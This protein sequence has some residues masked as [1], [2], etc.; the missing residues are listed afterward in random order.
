MTSNVTFSRKLIQFLFNLS[1]IL[2]VLCIVGV[3]AEECTIGVVVGSSTKDGRPILW[4]NRD[5]SFRDNEINFFIGPDY[6]FIGVI[7]ADDT[8]QI[9]AGINTAG[10]AII[11]SESLDLEGDSVD[12]EGFFM[13]KA[14]GICGS[15]ADF[16]QLLQHTN[17]SGRGTKSN[18][19]VIDALGGG[20]IYE[21]G[22]HTYVKFDASDQTTTHDGFIVRANFAM[23]GQGK[24]YSHWRYHCA[25]ELLGQSAPSTGID[26]K[27]ILQSVARDL[28]TDDLDPYPLPFKGTYENG[29]AG[30]INTNNCINRY[31]TACCVVFH[32]VK[33]SE[34]PKFATMWCILGEP[35]CG[36]AVPLWACAGQ[37]PPE[38]NGNKQSAINL[39]IQRFEKRVYSN[40]NFKN[41]CDTFALVRGK[42]DI[43][44]KVLS[45]EN[46][47][48][49]QT[50]QK[51][52]IWRANKADIHTMRNFEFKLA[53]QLLRYLR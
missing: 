10:F 33:P 16:E 40:P 26:I 9:W 44:T 3:N 41:Y 52:T 51:L 53:L 4:K 31:R 8:T 34:D 21:T 38:L 19:G 25:K 32:G 13:K 11:N 22:N 17:Q 49:N 27:Y 36:V 39:A 35:I 14:L 2:F 1:I 47:I 24:S 20:A 28:K 43:L 37:V 42:H 45:I 50:D 29:P 18:F 30:F 46:D 6:D 5:T 15:L 23:T 48:L 12:T 7:N